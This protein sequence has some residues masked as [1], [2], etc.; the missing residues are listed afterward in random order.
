MEWLLRTEAVLEECRQ[1]IDNTGSTGAEVEAF[2]S[3]YLLVVL[4]AEMQ[5]EMYRV[6]ELRAKKCGDDEICSFALASSKKILRSVKTGELSGFVGGFGSARKGRFVEALDE[7]TILQ[8]NSAVDNRHSVAHR[9]GAQVT[10]ADMAE[11]IMAAKRVLD[12]ALAA[13]IDGDAERG[14]EGIN[15][16]PGEKAIK[17]DVA[18]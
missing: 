2:L 13:L 12:S 6:V 10:L 17:G 8:Y 14:A 11:I 16:H 5:E 7:R 9:N 3:Q 15:P 1:H 4:C 18:D